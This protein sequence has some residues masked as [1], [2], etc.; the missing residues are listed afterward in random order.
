MNRAQLF[1]ER[2]D[3]TIAQ[4]ARESGTPQPT[5]YRIVCERTPSIVRHAIKIE[6]GTQGAIKAIDLMQFMIDVAKKETME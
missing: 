6:D 4:A 3:M 5:L 1:R 2:F